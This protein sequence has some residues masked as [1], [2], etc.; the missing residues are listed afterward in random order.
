MAPFETM[1]DYGYQ[2][3]S[4]CTRTE[5]YV[6]ITVRMPLLPEDTT[7][8]SLPFKAQHSRLSVL[9]KESTLEDEPPLRG[10]N[11]TTL[12]CSSCSRCNVEVTENRIVWLLMLKLF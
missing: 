4:L 5:C 8:Y 7:E 12:N 11:T 2:F 3:I 6:S 9:P 1:D 10:R